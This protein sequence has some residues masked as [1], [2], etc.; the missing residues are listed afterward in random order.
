[1]TKYRFSL[2]NDS[3][4]I[5]W[6]LPL[7]PPLPPPPPHT[8]VETAVEELKAFREDVCSKEGKIKKFRGH[9]G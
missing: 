8:H 7:Y 1:M 6:H 2:R 4:I 3:H 5:V 9:W